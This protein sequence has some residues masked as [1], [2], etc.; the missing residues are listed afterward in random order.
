MNTHF[1]RFQEFGLELRSIACNSGI[2]DSHREDLK[3]FQCRFESDRGHHLC[4]KYLAHSKNK[5]AFILQCIH[6]CIHICRERFEG[7]ALIL[8]ASQPRASALEQSSP[9][10]CLCHWTRTDPGLLTFTP[11]SCI[12]GK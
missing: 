9:S 2:P 1:V 10:I 11:A 6:K 3:S 12:Q 8:D 4:V 7:D 5:L